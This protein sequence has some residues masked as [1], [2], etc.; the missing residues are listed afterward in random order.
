M[1]VSSAEISRLESRQRDLK[2]ELNR[3]NAEIA[4]MRSQLTE[5]N[6]Q[7]L[8][9]LREQTKEQIQMHDKTMMEN[10]TRLL[11]RNNSDAMEI[12]RNEFEEY[13]RQ[14]EKVQT[15]L[16]EA[17]AEEHKKTAALLEAQKDFEKAYYERLEFAKG[18]A[19][20]MLSEVS[21]AV[22]KASLENPLEWF[23][24]GH[25]AVYRSR[26]Q[27]MRQWIDQ[28]FYE[29]A[30]GIG[31]NV[32]HSLK[33][34]I[35]EV[36]DRFHKW[37]NYYVILFQML[38][39]ERDLFFNRINRVSDDYKFF[40][41]AER[42]TDNK[43]TDDDT[44]YWSD[45]KITS[46]R[47]SFFRFS[48]ELNCFLIDGEVQYNE[49]KIRDFM[50]ANPDKSTDY[51]DIWL[52]SEGVKAISRVDEL[53]KTAEGMFDRI[54]CYEERYRIFRRLRKAFSR[55]RYIFH[56]ERWVY[57]RTEPLYISFS[58]DYDIFRV[59]TVIVPVFR[60]VDS[61]WINMV[62]CYADEG[63]DSDRRD[64][65]ISLVAEVL[66]KFDIALHGMETIRPDQSDDERIK[67]AIADMNFF[68]NGRLN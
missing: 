56:E 34:D 47:E 12:L 8:V 17:Y 61:K 31:D 59:D 46:A 55:I 23:L 49:K 45:G 15:E 37:L 3:K 1:A 66:G 60:N 68:I 44:D 9:S 65:I 48:D 40:I 32:L 11:D 36:E 62:R 50:I 7:R 28:G 43:M 22:N 16:R 42:I 67:I 19:E 53:R 10:Y 58:D 25:L 63:M 30:I 20:K 4:R 13:S 39:T 38:E 2:N 35:I 14:Y 33:I 21:E 18:T 27:N 52:Y 41:E 26:V 29:T 5:E 57:Q 54:S 24:K 64:D 51:K 6:V